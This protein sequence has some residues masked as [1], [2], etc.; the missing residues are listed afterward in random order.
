MKLTSVECILRENDLFDIACQNPA[1]IARRRKK[2]YGVSM[3]TR[4]RSIHA[5]PCL[6]SG[7][8][9]HKYVLRGFSPGLASALAP[10]R[11]VYGFEPN[12]ENF[13]CAQWTALL[14]E[15][16]N[17]SMHSSALGEVQ[18]SVF[19][20]MFEN[21]RAIG[22]GSQIINDRHKGISD[23]ADLGSVDIVVVDFILPNSASVGIMQLDVEGDE[24][25]ALRVPSK[26]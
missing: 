20:Q 17:V 6:R 13:V 21:G 4:N 7:Y 25:F 23:N 12:P 15:L 22:G 11:I 1:N 2:V 18:K 3:G 26:R 5:A 24:L 14:N 19:M 10:G 8:Y 16:T 9:S